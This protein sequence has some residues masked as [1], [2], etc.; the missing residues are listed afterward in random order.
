M[1]KITSLFVALCFALLP[2]LPAYAASE[3][4]IEALRG[5]KLYVYNWGEYISDGEDDTLDVNAAF[6]EKYGIKVI[7]NTFDNNETMYAKL[8]N[9]GVSFDIVIPSDYM[10]ERMINEDMLLKLDF[11]N[12]PNYKYIDE[13]YLNLAYDPDNEYSVP[14]NVGMVGLIYN[15]TMVKEPPTSWTALWDEQYAGQILMFNN[16]RDAFAIAQ[17]VLGLDYNTEYPGDWQAAAD[18]LKQQKKVIQSYVNDE[19]FNKMESGEAALAPYYAGDFL[20]MLDVNP[21]LG[22]VYPEEGVNAFVDAMCIPK[23]AQNKLAAEL[24]INFMLEKDVALANAEYICYASPNT[25]IINDPD[26]EYYGNEI[27]YPE[28]TPK[29]QIFINLSDQSLAGMNTLWDEV[30]N[31]QGENGKVKVNSQYGIYLLVF[32]VICA[33]IIIYKVSLKRYRNNY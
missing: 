14:Y 32:A 10:I 19:V 27:L 8:E 6:E 1:K 21:D 9:G 2:C 15:K 22:F 11:S 20:S 18:Q 30:K 28:K 24:Y 29:T 5:T 13:Q 26:Y 4:E 33:V 17:S 7:Y 12:I 16:P 25:Q 23:S 31:Y 3:S